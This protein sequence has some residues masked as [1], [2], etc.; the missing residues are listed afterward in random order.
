MANPRWRHRPEGSNWGDFGPDDQNGR[1]NLITPENVRQ[2]L[3]EAR[4]GLVF[5]LSLPLDYPGGNLLNERRHPPVLRPTLRGDRPNFNCT[6]TGP[7]RARTDVFND[8]LAIIHLQY[9]TQWDALSHVGGLFD[10]D[11]DGILEKVFYNGFRAG[12]HIVGPEDGK[13]AGIRT[14]MRRYSTSNAGALG[15]ERMASRGVQ[16]RGVMIDLRAHYGDART[17]VGYDELMRVIET[18]RVEVETGDMICLHTGFA[19]LLLD[20]DRKP[21]AAILH[22]ACAVLNGRD[23]RLLNWI[24]DSGLSVLIADNYA[25]EAFPAQ[26]GADECCSVLPIHEHC[27]FKNGIHLGELWHLT[28]LADWLRTNGRSRFLL[29]APPLRLPGAVGS[30]VTPIATV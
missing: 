12:E 28:P 3:A 24:T 27:L 8:D 25:V 11:G 15:I 10:V 22:G 7:E 9:S 30:P 23:S 26:P 4:E 2:G 17:L 16:G 29:T 1:L 20:M 5:C 18:D 19:Q 21:D 13:D 6:L 14:A